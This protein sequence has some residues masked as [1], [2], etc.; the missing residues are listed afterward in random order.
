MKDR[1]P[2][3][4]SRT[5]GDG[6]RQAMKYA[7]FNAAEMAHQLGWSPSRVSRILSGKRGGSS[8]DV[9]TF[10][11]VCGIRG[12]ERDRLMTL[13]L[14]QNDPGWLQNHGARLPTQ[15]LTLI[16]H[17]TKAQKISQLELNLIPGLLQTGEYAR[18]LIEE[19][20]TTPP[21]EIDARVAARLGRKN[22]FSRR[23]APLCIF[24][25][26]EFALRL[27]V[28]GP[29]VMSGQLHELL[30]VSVR[31]SIMLRIVPAARGAHAGINGS[32]QLLEFRNIK[33]VVYLESE[34]SSLFLERPV[35][36]DSYRTILSALDAT[37]LP[38]GQSREF[39]AGLAM[40]LYSDREANDHLAEE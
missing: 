40:E 20:G 34:T 29:V 30:K 2:T 39:I 10:L 5:L 8:V 12:E 31:P 38:E 4:R 14:D 21:G 27:P 22:V 18:C 15:L 6:L 11:A 13:T 25:V 23:Q 3:I 26:H 9:A 37:A 28:G 19:A 1:E 16:D 7:G 32:F 17:E 36:I 35:E 24:Y 33:P